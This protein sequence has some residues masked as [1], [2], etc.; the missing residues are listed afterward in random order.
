MSNSQPETSSDVPLLTREV[1]DLNPGLSGQPPAASSAE[2][3]N[4]NPLVA[5]VAGELASLRVD[6]QS[7][8]GEG[9]IGELSSLST[10]SS[11]VD[12]EI[13]KEEK[14]LNRAKRLKRQ[15]ARRKNRYKKNLK[16]L[17]SKLSKLPP[18][19]SK[20]SIKG[21]IVFS[22]VKQRMIVI[23]TIM[24]SNYVNLLADFDDVIPKPS[25]HQQPEL[26]QDVF[27]DECLGHVKKVRGLQ[28]N[29]PAVK[30]TKKHMHP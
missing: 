5:G 19:G 11:K 15:K 25:H 2:D 18:R 9:N 7:E 17:T 26:G 14:E 1:A 21:T 16:D 22:S 27:V 3:E 13:S 12:K 4:N 29:D 8:T 30:L 6:D 24:N 23:K 10:A 28:K 20:C